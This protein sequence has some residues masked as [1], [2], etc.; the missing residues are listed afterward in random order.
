MSEYLVVI[1]HDGEGWGAYVQTFPVSAL[2]D[3]AV[4]RSSS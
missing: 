4:T 2:P 3:K 1:E